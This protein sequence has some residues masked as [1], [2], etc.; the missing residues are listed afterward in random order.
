MHSV[1]VSTTSDRV[2]LGVLA[3]LFAAS[4]AGTMMWCGSMSA[5]DGMPMSGGWTMSMMWMRMPG[6]TWL[7]AAAAFLGMWMVMMAAMM[8][9]SLMPMLW[10][11]RRAIRQT[12]KRRPGWLAMLAGAGYFFVWALFGIVAFPFGAALAEIE[13]RLP[14]LAHAAPVATGLVVLIAGMF[15]FTAW[16]ARHLACCREMPEH[17]RPPS[18]HGGTAWRHGVQLGARCVTCCAGPTAVL[19][20]VGVMD[21]RAMTVV[22]AAITAE[23]LAPAGMRADRLTGT[24]AIGTGLFMIAA[25]VG[26]T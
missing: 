7:G 5:M 12:A 18:A 15:Q 11:Y 24:V 19:L 23:R 17:R 21:L 16:K 14:P 9:P 3:L 2:F 1:S 10:R 26:L 20:A 13:M 22:T 8:L 4:V 25:A 6:Q